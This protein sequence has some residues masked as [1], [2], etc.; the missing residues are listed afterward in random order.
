MTSEIAIMN[1]E[2]IA[3]AADSTVT[4]GR[5]TKTWE[6]ANKIFT[7][8]KYHPVGI[9]IYGSAE[10]MEIPWE[11][12]IKMYRANLGK[13]EFSTIQEYFDDFL[14]F[15]KT[16]KSLTTED[17]EFT[18]FFTLVESYYKHIKDEISGNIE[19]LFE[20]AVESSKVVSDNEIEEL[21]TD[22][23]KTHHEN[24][25]KSQFIHGCSEKTTKK[26]LDMH[27]E[28]IDESMK[29]I[30]QDMPLNAPRDSLLRE[31]AVSLPIKDYSSYSVSGIVIAGF[32]KDEIFPAI[33]V[34]EIEGIIDGNMKY[35]TS[36][37]QKISRD[38]ISIVYPFAQTEMVE[39]FMQGVDPEYQKLIDTM[40][41]ELID[42]LPSVFV[43]SIKSFSESEKE[44]LLQKLENIYPEILEKNKQNMQS[45]RRENFL[46]EITTVV[47]QLPKTEL[48]SLA[49]ALIN[50]TSLKRKMSM[51]IETV[52]GPI[53]VAVI[54]KGDGFI[55]I[56]RK[57][58][59]TAETNPNF[60][61]RYFMGD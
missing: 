23:I 11:T 32:G 35:E 27:S 24:W 42:E 12:I 52:G 34:C 41:E 49:D 38:T 55:W 14:K 40:L 17:A 2:A 1:K 59:F 8:S 3:L 25:Q 29:D 47:A 45:Y 46:D 20:N 50:L 28:E 43:D 53:D 13:K 30:F 37:L 44:E 15:L 31:I 61:T 51:D 21:I 54:S 33:Q 16:E 60:S 10:Y 18:H 9:M 57:H 19:S 4:L 56:K 58:Y 36:E 22:M 26:L 39:T 48:A 6:S 7:L 5:G